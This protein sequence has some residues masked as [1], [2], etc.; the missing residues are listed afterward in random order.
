MRPL[1]NRDRGQAEPH[2]PRREQHTPQ[3]QRQHLPQQAEPVERRRSP[4]RHHPAEVRRVPVRVG[5]LRPDARQPREPACQSLGEV[6]ADLAVQVGRPAGQGDRERQPGQH[7]AAVVAGEVAA[8]AAAIP[9]DHRRPLHRPGQQQRADG[10][11]QMPGAEPD[12]RLP[13]R[14]VLAHHRNDDQPDQH[15]ERHRGRQHQLP[16]GGRQQGVQRRLALGQRRG[17]IVGLGVGRI[18]AV[19]PLLPLGGG[20]GLVRRQTAA[21]SFA[22]TRRSGEAK[23]H[24]SHPWA[25]SAG[26]GSRP[27]KAGHPMPT[28]R[29][30]HRRLVERIGPPRRRLAHDRSRPRNRTRGGS[31]PHWPARCDGNFCQLVCKPQGGR[32]S[33]SRNQRSR[34][35]SDG[36][37][38]CNPFLSFT[39]VRPCGGQHRTRTSPCDRTDS[40]AFLPP[41]A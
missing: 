17:G 40:T 18:D 10:L 3:P 33:V 6:A 11:Q 20:P 41:S 19:P 7:P 30:I 9:V 25:R 4:E 1:Q 2:Q 29:R 26:Q 23:A 13:G 39:L 14:P 34:R 21:A 31:L 16:P 28:R 35:R 5:Q 24:R 37:G 36:S 8:A 38:G 12:D 15:P 22:D 32:S 27:R